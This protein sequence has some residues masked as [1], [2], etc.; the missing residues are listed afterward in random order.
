MDAPN[1]AGVPAVRGARRA[2]L[3]L[4]GLAAIH[5]SGH[6]VGI[7]RLD[8]AERDRLGQGHERGNGKFL[9]EQPRMDSRVRKRATETADASVLLQH[10]EGKQAAGTFAPNGE[11]DGVAQLHRWGNPKGVGTDS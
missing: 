1:C 6:G 2:R 7:G 9:E 8:P 10:M 4:H 5:E 3:C 11:A